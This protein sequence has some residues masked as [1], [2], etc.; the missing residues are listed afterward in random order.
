M[1]QENWEFWHKVAYIRF[2]IAKPGLPSL[3][4]KTKRLNARFFLPTFHSVVCGKNTKKVCRN[5]R[6]CGGA[7]KDGKFCLKI[8]FFAKRTWQE[9]QRFLL[10]IARNINLC[11]E[12]EERFKIFPNWR[13]WIDFFVWERQMSLKSVQCN[14]KWRR[15][16]PTSKL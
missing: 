14:A 7:L 11:Q 5:C 1:C 2:K 13:R 3:D 15:E 8:F 4:L 12:W 6:S 10:F 9:I 16:F